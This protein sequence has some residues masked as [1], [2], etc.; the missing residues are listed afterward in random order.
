MLKGKLG[1]RIYPFWNKAPS[2]LIS[3]LT[4]A[5]LLGVAGEAFAEPFHVWEKV[6]IVLSAEKT[7]ENPY[8]EVVVWVDLRGPGFEKRC[9]GFWDGG[10]TFRVRVLGNAVG[11]WSWT[12]AS[13]QDDPGLNG[14]TDEF[15]AVGWSEAEKQRNPSRRGMIQASANGHAFEYADGEPF[16]L[17]GDT[18]WA[19]PTF[20][21]RWDDDDRPRLM[22]PEAGFKDYVRFRKD[23]GFNCV[24]MIAFP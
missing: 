14:K 23:Q 21:Y 20:R 10:D 13:N 4:L 3:I 24:A 9:Y 6:E 22:G 1:I 17:L 11:E 5:V 8:T 15:T 7:Y 16:F 2:E 18:W 19:T 12:S